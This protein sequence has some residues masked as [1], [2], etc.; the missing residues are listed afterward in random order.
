M[1]KTKLKQTK[2]FTP[3]Q[4]GTL[5]VSFVHSRS[6]AWSGKMCNMSYRCSHTETSAGRASD[7]GWHKKLK[8]TQRFAQAMTLS[9]SWVLRLHN[10]FMNKGYSY[11]K[12][13]LIQSMEREF[14]SS[15]FRW[16]CRETCRCIVAMSVTYF[17]LKGTRHDSLSGSKQPQHTLYLHLVS[18]EF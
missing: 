18:N 12:E 1:K 15:S 7:A 11:S 9:L 10:L 16:L 17:I 8:K 4:P 13:I 5:G 6:K 14:S 3:C 2:Y